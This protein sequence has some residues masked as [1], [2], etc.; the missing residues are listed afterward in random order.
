[1]TSPDTPNYPMVPSDSL[2]ANAEQPLT[3]P[4]N[5]SPKAPWLIAAGLGLLLLSGGVG[6]WFLQ[7]G[8]S[9][10][11]GFG[12]AGQGLPVKLETVKQEQIEE[13]SEF[14]GS[15]EAQESVVLKPEI[16]GR[17]SQFYVAPGDFVEAGAPL[18]Q[19][20]ATKR[21]AE[22]ASVLATVNSAR[23]AQS[24]AASELQA[25]QAERDSAAADLRLKE[26]DYRRIA[27]LVDD[28]VL[29]R[30]ELDVA[31]RDRESA[32]A[33]LNAVNRRIEASRADLAESQAGLREAQANAAL[34]DAELQDTTVFAPFA[35]IVGDIPVK[36][37]DF[38][39]TTTTL[40]TVTQNSTLDLRIS[41]PLERRAQI[42][43]GLPVKLSDAQGNELA[44][45]QLSFI[46]PAVNASAQ[47][48]LVKATF[49]NASGQLLNGQYVRARV[50]WSQKPGVLVP[51]SAIS[52]VAGQAFVFV[53][54]EA[55][56]S[57][58]ATAGQPSAGQSPA[59]GQ[60]MLVAEQREVT[61]GALQGD[62]YQILEGLRP[63]ERIVVS[64]IL[65]L[66]DG[67]PIMPEAPAAPS[68][69]PAP[70]S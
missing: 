45:G 3:N 61:L 41:I 26:A 63:G 4:S 46:S 5:P 56:P 1:M 64:G 31:V 25:L 14:V 53:A 36:L 11:P 42:R 10:A 58:E 8:R 48:I 18:V 30:Q 22:F 66:S 57:P 29:A 44:I 38:V 55:E 68:P 39:S 40:T 28:G 47:S 15:L 70:G 19:L 43:P 51:S 17:V 23:A 35:G 21:Q 54:K 32:A 69:S 9:N 16:E 33:S 24:S 20:S 49:N 7:A 67:A 65:N 52:R 62:R 50:L 59:S 60:P 12:A 34:A 13:T 2:Q 6:W 27:S 37:G